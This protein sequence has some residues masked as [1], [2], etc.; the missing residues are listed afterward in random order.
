MIAVIRIF[1]IVLIM[2]PA[3]AQS[4]G[5]SGGGIGGDRGGNHREEPDDLVEKIS[6]ETHKDRI[7]YFDQEGNPLYGCFTEFRTYLEAR[8]ACPYYANVTRVW[9][10]K[11][12]SCSCRQ[13][14]TD[15]M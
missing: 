2:V 4:G 15:G 8:K 12:W 10:K 6:Y 14:R 9:G 5:G 1:L 13:E 7:G 11:T 3:L